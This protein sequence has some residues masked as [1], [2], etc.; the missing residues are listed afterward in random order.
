[1]GHLNTLF[2]NGAERAGAPTSGNSGDHLW[3]VDMVGPFANPDNKQTE[4]MLADLVKNFFGHRKFKFHQ[5]DPVMG[6]RETIELG[7]GS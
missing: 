4:V 3:L 5:T 6:K 7:G 2:E 1:M